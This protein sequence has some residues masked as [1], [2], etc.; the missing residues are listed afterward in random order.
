S[1][2]SFLG[3]QTCATTHPT[4]STTSLA[5]VTQRHENALASRH[6][7]NYSPATCCTSNVNPPPRFREDDGG[8]ASLHRSS[9]C[10]ART[11]H[12]AIV[13]PGEPS[14]W[15]RR[16]HRSDARCVCCPDHER[17]TAM[18]YL[19]Y[20]AAALISALGLAGGEAR[21]NTCQADTL[22]C[23]TSMPI[24]GYCEC[25]GRGNT[26]GGTVVAAPPRGPHQMGRPGGCGAEPNAPGCRVSRSPGGG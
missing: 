12:R 19:P 16:S 4:K 5:D 14:P 23:P 7:P 9:S 26:E 3:K 18:R 21:A 10:R 13:A 2:A 8:I 15:F 22:T 1:A 17:L 20:L 11:R 24:D 6:P 25:R